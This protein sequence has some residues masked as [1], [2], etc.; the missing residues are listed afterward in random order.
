MINQIN[1]TKKYFV[2]GKEKMD[3]AVVFE[4]TLYPLFEKQKMI[5]K[6]VLEK[7]NFGYEGVLPG[8]ITSVPH[9]KILKELGQTKNLIDALDFINSINSNASYNDDGR[10]LHSNNGGDLNRVL[11]FVE[12]EFFHPIKGRRS[13]ATKSLLLFITAPPVDNDFSALKNHLK[14]KDIQLVVVAVNSTMSMPNVNAWFSAKD[15]EHNDV[16][17][18][19]VDSLHKGYLN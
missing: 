10:D 6:D 14:S 1:I 2:T 18:F 16:N 13:D 12:K 11:V 5:A 7:I 8:F 4:P 3:L 15:L 17:E 19:I 9:L